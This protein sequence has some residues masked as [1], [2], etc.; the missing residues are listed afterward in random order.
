M[1]RLAENVDVD[2]VTL[3]LVLR[4]ALGI[5]GPLILG[6]MAWHTARIRSTQSA[7]GILYVVVIFVFLGELI[8]QLLQ[9]MTGLTL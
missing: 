3:F 8:S 9:T 6:G 7:T 2:E 1:W 4:W 5:L